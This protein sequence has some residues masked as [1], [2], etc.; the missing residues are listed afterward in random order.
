[1]RWLIVACVLLV[2]SAQVLY[3]GFFAAHSLVWG[4]D[5][6]H[7]ARF[8]SLYAAIPF[9]ALTLP[10]LI[11]LRGQRYAAALA[12][13]SASLLAEALLWRAM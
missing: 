12:F 6:L 7:I 3:I 13:A 8:V 1:M 4:D 11:L 5:G 2:A 10:A 9:V